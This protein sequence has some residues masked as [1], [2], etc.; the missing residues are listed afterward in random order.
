MQ[1]LPAVMAWA[2][3]TVCQFTPVASNGD[4]RQS[5]PRGETDTSKLA[6]ELSSDSQI[7]L[8]GDTGF[9]EASSRWNVFDQPTASVIVVPGV[10]EDV[11]KTVR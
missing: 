9:K 10:A 1:L 3:A 8:P 7:L 5:C 11:A 4:G 6:S 2:A